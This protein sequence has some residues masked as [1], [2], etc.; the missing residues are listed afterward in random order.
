MYIH[1]TGMR[2]DDDAELEWH[3]EREIAR[4][5]EIWEGEPELPAEHPDNLPGDR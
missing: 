2:R 5:E 4:I 1:Q 3:R